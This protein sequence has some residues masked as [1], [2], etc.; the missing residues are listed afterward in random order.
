MISWGLS[1]IFSG[2]LV[3]EIVRNVA[4]STIGRLV[5]P[6][7]WAQAVCGLLDCR[8]RLRWSWPRHRQFL[9]RWSKSAV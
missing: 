8:L 3:R 7:T 9:G 1:L 5:Q 6:L 4:E 2:V